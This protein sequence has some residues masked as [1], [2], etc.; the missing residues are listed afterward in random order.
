[1]FQCPKVR[2][3]FLG[4]VLFALAV[5]GGLAGFSE[6]ITSSLLRNGVMPSALVWRVFSAI[7]GAATVPAMMAAVDFDPI[8]RRQKK[9]AALKPRELALF[10][11]ARSV[12]NVGFQKT[13]AEKLMRN[14]E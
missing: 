6:T 11:N 8:W 3:G 13:E 5:G 4:F 1:M 2:E 12:E 10:S 14:P 9:L 7:V